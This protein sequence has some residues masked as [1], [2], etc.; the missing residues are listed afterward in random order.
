MATELSIGFN[1][2]NKRYK[3]A[4]AGL[5][6]L[7]TSLSLG[8][9]KTAPV[10]RHELHDFLKTVAEALGERHKRRWPGGTTPNTLSMRTGR[11][12]RS[13]EESVRVTGTT[14]DNIRG[15]IGASF[16]MKIHE[17]GGTIKA[18][19]AKYLTIPLPAALDSRGV[20]WRRSARLWDNTFIR[21]SRKGNLIIF[22][23][24]PSGRVVPLYLLRKSVRIPPRLGMRKTLDAGLPFFVDRTTQRML[25]A[26]LKAL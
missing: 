22:R 3:D 18:K 12:I 23:K 5:K 1:F 25:Q 14:L 4:Q 17:K 9:A 15:R 26:M 20:P 10:L 16:R 8:V 6:A 7:G 21:K 19:R 13:I 2:R 11:G 24:E